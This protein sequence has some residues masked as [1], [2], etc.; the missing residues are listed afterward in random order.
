MGKKKKKGLCVHLFSLWKQMKCQG[1]LAVLFLLA[2]HQMEPFSHCLFIDQR[3]SFE[4]SHTFTSTTLQKETPREIRTH[5]RHLHNKVNV[6]F[7]LQITNALDV[8]CQLGRCFK[9]PE[10]N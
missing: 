1:F 7:R 4:T 3:A 5:H 9:G 8:Y 6:H 2:K 10:L